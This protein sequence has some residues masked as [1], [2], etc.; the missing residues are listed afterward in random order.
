MEL[1]LADA[2]ATGN[3]MLVLDT[4]DTT[5]PLSAERLVLVELL[6]EL[7]LHGLEVLEVF[8]VHFG[9]GKAGSGL[10]VDEL[11]EGSLSAD[12]A[13]GNF[14]LAAEGGEMDNGLNGVDVVGNNNELGLVLFNEGSHVV[15]TELDVDGL[16]GLGVLGLSSGLKA[17]LLLLAGLGRVL[18]EEL[19]E[20]GS[21]VL[22]NGVVELGNG[23]GDLEA[24]HEDGLLALDAHVTGPLH[25]TG[26]V[27]LGLDITTDTE[28]AGVL[29][30]E[31]GLVIGLAG[32]TTNNDLLSFSNFLNL[33]S[34]HV[35]K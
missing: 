23:G 28:V 9:E 2:L 14:L 30:E 12:K 8:L 34:R 6:K 7:L 17:E 32:G 20:L 33:I 1:D 21:L 18:S 19:E 11:A 4:H 13:E 22:V 26:K 25:E 29:S 35:S 27:A 10:E 31:G 3:H 15:K 24:A 5:A 16:G